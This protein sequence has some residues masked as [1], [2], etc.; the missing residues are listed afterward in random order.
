MKKVK[1][2]F[3]EGKDCFVIFEG[4]EIRLHPVT[5]ENGRTRLNIYTFIPKYIK[6]YEEPQYQ[7]DEPDSSD[8]VDSLEIEGLSIWASTDEDMNVSWYID[9]K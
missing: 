9:R 3:I 8:T 7:Y 1:R 4:K 5:P 6:G 2:I